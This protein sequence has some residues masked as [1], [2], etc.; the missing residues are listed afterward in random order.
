[1]ADLGTID[2]TTLSYLLFTVQYDNNSAG[3]QRIERIMNVFKFVIWQ[4][5]LEFFRCRSVVVTCLLSL[6]FFFGILFCFNKYRGKIKMTTYQRLHWKR[7]LCSLHTHTHSH[8]HTLSLFLSLTLDYFISDI[9]YPQR[10]FFT[11]MEGRGG[12]SC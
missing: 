12:F 1:M 5:C 6:W 7:D 10:Y 8:T 2:V 4:L 11:T 3:S 9:H